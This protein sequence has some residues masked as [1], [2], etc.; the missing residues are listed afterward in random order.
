LWTSIPKFVAAA[1][2]RTLVP[3]RC[4]ITRTEKEDCQSHP[5]EYAVEMN[6][7]IELKMEGSVG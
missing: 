7:L 4:P 5:I 2:N 6:R 3:K 1:M